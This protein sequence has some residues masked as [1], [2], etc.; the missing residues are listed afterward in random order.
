[1]LPKPFA[2]EPDQN[3][4]SA[5]VQY[6]PFLLVIDSS[7]RKFMMFADSLGTFL[8]SAQKVEDTDHKNL[9]LP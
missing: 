8:E 3:K 7:C 9:N 5:K 2:D 6:L 1:M 4:A